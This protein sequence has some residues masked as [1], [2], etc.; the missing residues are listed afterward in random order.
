MNNRGILIA[1]DQDPMY[2][3]EWKERED[4]AGGKYKTAN[5]DY[6]DKVTRGPEFT[7]REESRKKAQT[8][9]VTTV[10][11]TSTYKPPLSSIN[12]FP[13]LNQKVGGFFT[14]DE[15][16]KN[17]LM[18]WDIYDR[19]HCVTLGAMTQEEIKELFESESDAMFVF[20]LVVSDY[21]KLYEEMGEVQAKH[22]RASKLVASLQQELDFYRAKDDEKAA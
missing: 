19:D 16:F 17:V 20:D 13:N 1:N 15:H 2:L 9:A 14:V 3:G 6:F 4:D 7:R 8:T 12:K 21:A 22:D 11:T 18:D 5:D 10:T